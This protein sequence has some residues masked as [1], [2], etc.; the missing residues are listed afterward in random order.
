MDIQPNW[1]HLGQTDNGYA[2]NSY[3]TDHP[4]MVLGN[5]T[6]EST[7]H[8]MDYTVSPIDS[9]ELSDQLHD[10]IKYINGQYTE[11]ELPELGED[12]TVD[13]SLPADPDVKNYSYTVVDGNVYYRENSRM[14]RPD[15]NAT[16]EERIKGMVALRDCVNQLI[17]LQMNAYTPDGG[18]FLQCTGCSLLLPS[19]ELP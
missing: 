12:E 7:A 10:A 17:D 15:L 6:E 2:I 5:S 9:L 11:A 16:A 19:R 3:F 8:G 18:A 1:V 14:V 4:E 13:T